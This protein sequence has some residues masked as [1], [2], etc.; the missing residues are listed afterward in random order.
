MHTP[1]IPKPGL[2]QDA[3]HGTLIER[4][5]TE[6]NSWG[7]QPIQGELLKTRPPGQHVHDPLGPQGAADPASCQAA[8][9]YDLAAVPA[10][11]SCDETGR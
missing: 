5:A 10:R 1:R 7:Y 11:T 8:H 4:L 9:G 2:R 6:N 3:V